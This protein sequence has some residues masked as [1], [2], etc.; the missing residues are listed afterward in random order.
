VRNGSDLPPTTQGRRPDPEAGL[1]FG[2]LGTAAFPVD[3]L[4]AV[5]E[6]WRM[7]RQVDPVL[8]RSRLAFRGHFGWQSADMADGRRALLARFAPDG[9]V[10]GG[11]VARVDVAAT[12]AEW[13]ALVFL[14][15]G[16]RYMTS[17]KIYEY[18][19]TGL[20]IMSAHDGDHGALEVLRGYPP[21]IPPPA[22]IA[23]DLLSESFVAFARTVLSA[24][25]KQRE[26]ALVHASPCQRRGQ[27]APAVRDLVD[28]MG[29]PPPLADRHQGDLTRASSPT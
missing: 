1:T 12:Y 18:M 26:A 5:L 13:D 21:W 3:Y 6:G 27:L 15:S 28:C 14:I 7:A 8:A 10:F 4:R 19:S 22:K 23:A 20:P 2:Y 9:V 16:G 17:G 29:E 25:E 11:P 24:T